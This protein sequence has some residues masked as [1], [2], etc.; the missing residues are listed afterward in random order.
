M[1][2]IIFYNGTF[3]YGSWPQ[4]VRLTS[5]GLNK[6]GVPNDIVI[7]FWPPLH[8]EKRDS[9]ENVHFMFKSKS[10]RYYEK[11]KILYLFYYLL[12]IIKGYLFLKRQQDI[13]AVIFAQGSY[14]ECYLILKLCKK[15][16]IKFI[17]DLVDE[18]AK[19]YEGAKS[20]KD[21]IAIWNRD[22]YEK[23]IVK[24]ADYLFV[25]SS[26][27]YN[28]YKNLFPSLKIINSTPSLIDLDDFEKR[29]SLDISFLF[30]GN[31]DYLK[32]RKNKFLYAGSCARP[33]GIFFFLENLVELKSRHYFD[34]F[35][36]FLI[37]EGNTNILIKKVNELKITSNVYIGKSVPQ[38]YIPAIYN[39][40][41]DYFFIP[42]HGDLCAN[43]GFP[44]KTAELLGAG[45][46][47]IS[48]N[49]SDLS[50]YLINEFNS[51]VS[52]VGDKENYQLNLKKLLFDKE[53]C[54]KI[55]KN[56]KLTAK[57]NF[58]YLKGAQ[59]YVDII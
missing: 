24:N 43:A 37:S 6:L 26:Y 57:E 27:L 42:E 33:N 39:Q 20:L 14:L 34:F 46:P 22:L 31:Y 23:Y 7:S 25:I 11:S 13:K 52:E 47:I 17:I 1:K 32:S 3:P 4:R 41:A 55:S 53:L 44:S 21:R 50:K 15:R 48:T 10:K 28:K 56:A 5:K 58:D 16:K 8:E 59:K 19:K 54:Q 38:K 9:P 49:F 30:P 18:N 51:L 40:L 35:I 29:K 45:K 12:G 2:V 36:I